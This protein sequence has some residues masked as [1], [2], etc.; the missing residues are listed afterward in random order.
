MSEYQG[1]EP[2]SDFGFSG[3]FGFS[4]GFAG[5]GSK[6]KQTTGLRPVKNEEC[7]ALSS[8]SLLTWVQSVKKVKICM[9]DTEDT[10]RGQCWRPTRSHISVQHGSIEVSQ[11][12]VPAS[13]K[14]RL[15]T[16]L[17]WLNNIDIFYIFSVHMFKNDK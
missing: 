17:C 14:A 3:A 5:S 12:A 15:T 11:A 10:I 2:S 4:V 13:L 9:T 7:M 16:N 8:R 1:D 6:Q